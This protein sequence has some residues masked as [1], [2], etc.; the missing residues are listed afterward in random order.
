MGL[1]AL[2]AFL[3][4]MAP[5]NGQMHKA[6]VDRRTFF[7]VAGAVAGTAV[8][9]GITGA[10]IHEC[11]KP[12]EGSFE[13][14][15]GVLEKHI[16]SYN[17]YKLHPSLLSEAVYKHNFYDL[18][19]YNGDKV[20]IFDKDFESTVRKMRDR[21]Y[22]YYAQPSSF[23]SNTDSFTFGKIVDISDEVYKDNG[24]N[25]PFK[26]VKFREIAESIEEAADLPGNLCY[27]AFDTAYLNLT[28]AEKFADETIIKRGKKLEKKDDGSMGFSDVLLKRTYL[29]FKERAEN[30]GTSIQ[31]EFINFL[32][33]S[34]IK[35]HEPEHRYDKKETIAYL[36]QI[37]NSPDDSIAALYFARINGAEGV[38]ELFKK[39]GFSENDLASMQPGDMS[40]IAKGLIK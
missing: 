24:R 13:E 27:W 16:N 30:N 22:A 31:E 37:A 11:T 1:G 6:H 17:R 25:D 20:N 10:V 12:E 38:F 2:A 15:A 21:G 39:G 7:K 19:K 5:E 9:A 33:E 18:L 29:L 32:G 23:D 14:F 36:N 35:H 26:I 28:Y 8:G 3:G 40:R 34:A 4:L